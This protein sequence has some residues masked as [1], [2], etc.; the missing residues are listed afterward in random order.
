[1]TDEPIKKLKKK[2]IL[3]LI[4][5]AEIPSG[6]DTNELDFLLRTIILTKRNAGG[7]QWKGISL[8][9]SIGLPINNQ[10]KKKK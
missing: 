6:M 5:Y 10:F 2:Q 8:Y 1:M 3:C 7:L 4:F 9:K